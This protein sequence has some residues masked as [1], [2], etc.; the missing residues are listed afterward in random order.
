MPATTQAT[1][2]DDGPGRMGHRSGPAKWHAAEP[3][4][5]ASCA[6]QRL[7]RDAWALAHMD[8]RGAGEQTN[9]LREGGER[10]AAWPF[11]N[12]ACRC[13]APANAPV[14]PRANHINSERS[15][16]SAARPTASTFV[17]SLARSQPALE[18]RATFR[19]SPPSAPLSELHEAAGI[20]KNP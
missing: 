12:K 6:T 15:E 16:H 18:A 9:L 10:C 4:W 11:P 14:K 17:S 20:P 7:D 5:L 1:R 3:R 19:I 2:G 13:G 8:S